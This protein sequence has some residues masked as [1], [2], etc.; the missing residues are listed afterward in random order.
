MAL[1]RRR[2]QQQLADKLSQEADRNPWTML[3]QHQALSIRRTP[4]HRLTEQLH[5]SSGGQ[6]C[7]SEPNASSVGTLGIGSETRS[8]ST[9]M[10]A[11]K[12]ES[13]PVPLVCPG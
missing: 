11:E 1:Q 10:Q 5:K 6:S 3:Q 7:E 8:A 13:V 2:R 9:S 4:V 12:V